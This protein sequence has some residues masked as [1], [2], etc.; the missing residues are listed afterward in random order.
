MGS[1]PKGSETH[2]IK[3]KVEFKSSARNSLAKLPK[4]IQKRIQ[5]VITVLETNPLPPKAEKLK[6]RDA[7]RI[8]V[9]DYRIIYSIENNKLLIAV[10]AIGHRREIYR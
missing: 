6:G 3:Y 2:L 4:K 5:G 8:R 10:V 1:G 7:Y 9:S